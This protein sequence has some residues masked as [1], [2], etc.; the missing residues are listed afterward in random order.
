[1]KRLIGWFAENGVAA[2]LLMFVLVVG[3]LVTIPSIRQQIFPEISTGMISVS[4]LYPGAAPEE[5][6]ETINIRVEEKVA[7]LE[8]VKKIT[9][10]ATEGVGAVVIE[11]VE[12]SDIRELLADVKSQVDAIDTFPVEAERP[13]ISEL[14]VRNHVVS[15]SIYGDA[16]ERT[17]KHLAE[18]VRDELT[19]SSTVSL[20]DLTNVRPYEISIELD[21]REM[22]RFGL[23]FSEV[24]DA[25]RG[26]SLDLPAGLMRT[27]SGEILLRSKGQAYVGTDFEELVVRTFPDGRRL[28]VRDVA[29]VRDAFAE[30]DQTASFDGKPA[31]TLMV[32]RVGT[33]RALDVSNAVRKLAVE[34]GRR[35]PDG[36]QIAVWNDKST[37]LRDRLETLLRNGAQGLV[38][39]FLSLALFLQLRLAVWVTLGIPVSFLGTL[40][41]M[42]TMDISINVLS[43]FCFILVLGIVVDDAIVVGENVY[44]KKEEGATGLD[45]VTSG[46]GEV[47]I[48][49]IFGVLTTVAAF[50]PMFGIPGA[51]GKIM[52]VFPAVVIPT[53]LFSLVESQLVLPS[54]L[55]H[56]L[57]DGEGSDKKP[58]GWKRVQKVF[59]RV[60][61]FVIA[62][63][64]R[65]VLNR[66][67]EAR[68][69]TF[70]TGVGVVMITAACVAGGWV[71]LTWFPAAEADN[72]VANLEMPIG[73]PRA[74]TEEMLGHLEDSVR[75]VAADL[76]REFGDGEGAGSIRHILTSLGDHP[77]KNDQGRHAGGREGSGGAGGHV[78]EVNVELAPSG[79][80]LVSSA[81]MA[82][83]WREQAGS[84]PGASELTFTASLFNTGRAIQ[85]ELASSNMSHLQQAAERLKTELAGYAGV[86]AIG[87]S[88]RPGKQEIR[89]GI[90]PEAEALGLSLED[91]AR[92]VRQAFYGEEVQRVARGR[93]DI[94]VMVRYPE[95]LRSQVDALSMMR[96]RTAAGDEVPF[97]RVATIEQERGYATIGRANRRRVVTISADVDISL[98]NANEI[99]GDLSK[100][101]L[102]RLSSDYPGL[103]FSLEGDRRE[104]GDALGALGRGL[105]ISLLLIYALMAIPLR[106]YVQPLMVMS[107][108]PFGVVG[109]VQAHMLLGLEISFLSVFGIM[110]LVGVVVNDSLVLTDAVNRRRANE[111]EDLVDS[112]HRAGAGRFRA[113]V[114]TSL[115]TFA[116]LVPLLL[117]RSLQAQFLVPMAVSLGFGVLFATPVS[118]ILVPC[119]YLILEDGRVWGSGLWGRLRAART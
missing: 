59:G 16:D 106:S 60:M 45:A 113:I 43:L 23:G 27:E 94:K 115:T 79:E 38:L 108:I 74:V 17:L 119:L 42:P 78:G 29:T 24:A 93:E 114:L 72:V 34:A 84:I 64:Y 96:V 86:Y 112:V 98:G 50:L 21:E 80:R 39:V 10:T 35:M 3:G 61:D 88:F 92:Q 25:V 54:H 51:T 99:V 56:V 70:A 68:Y 69:L 19:G 52:R 30:A 67:L 87:D 53:L 36:V 57:V 49:V 15:L 37:V 89:L 31:A 12:G 40:W 73:T 85:V 58:N 9:S 75:V 8:D 62:R 103:S 32:F 48:P 95:E 116:G 100:A 81:E 63:L 66:A 77:F 90:R 14:S 11:A 44:R 41:L 107:A 22:R 6:E 91:L 110:A 5:V 33:Q 20:V 97:D 18:Q 1:M 82:R 101:F 2:N 4:V 104:Q 65:P 47:A 71:R 117:E 102:P 76:E 55:K 105:L 28:L 111:D 13:I 26:S 109:A 83:R 118:L 46:A 7:G